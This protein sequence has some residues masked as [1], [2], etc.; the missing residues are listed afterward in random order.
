VFE[1]ISDFGELVRQG[2]DD[3]IIL[4][5]NRLCVGLVEH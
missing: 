2:V 5:C 1:V 3:P 4:G